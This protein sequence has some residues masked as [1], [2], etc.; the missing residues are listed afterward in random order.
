MNQSI[1]EGPSTGHAATDVYQDNH[2]LGTTAG[3]DEPIGE[4][5]VVHVR[6]IAL[7]VGPLD[8]GKKTQKTLRTAKV[9]GL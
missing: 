4:P 7:R 2:V 6:A 9:L 8:T 5:A 3:A 1:N